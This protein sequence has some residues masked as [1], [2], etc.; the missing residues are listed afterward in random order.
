[1]L[2]LGKCEKGRSKVFLGDLSGSKNVSLST[3]NFCFI[4]RNNSASGMPRSRSANFWS[5][6]QDISLLSQWFDP[7]ITSRRYHSVLFCKLITQVAQHSTSYEGSRVTGAPRLILKEQK[8]ARMR[9]ASC[10]VS[11]VYAR[12]F[13]TFKDLS[14]SFFKIRCWILLFFASSFRHYLFVLLN[15]LFITIILLLVLNFYS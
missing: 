10:T 9:A 3:L 15:I 7:A 11:R 13:E 14:T 4:S 5:R 12:I 8:C 2:T 1:M 6:K